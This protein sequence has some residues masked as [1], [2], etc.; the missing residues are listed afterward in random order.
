MP[1]PPHVLELDLRIENA[2]Y[3]VHLSG[4]QADLLAS[5]SSLRSLWHFGRL[6]W[7]LRYHKP[8]GTKLHIAWRGFRLS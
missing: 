2:G 1:L 8:Q 7:P 5:F 4:S 6:F 3:R